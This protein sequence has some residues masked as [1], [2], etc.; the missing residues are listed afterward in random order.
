MKTTEA[1]SS[2]VSTIPS[3][4]QEL[5]DFV[6]QTEQR[7]QDIAVKLSA[8]RDQQRTQSFTEP[9][10]DQNPP[11]FID[12]LET[13]ETDVEV[14]VEIDAEA[15]FPTP[16]ENTVPDSQPGVLHPELDPADPLARLQAIKQRIAARIDQH[17][18][19]N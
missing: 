7:L 8:C 17:D 1:Q 4:Q 16:A 15:E 2:K 12:Q 10:C 13:P 5:T 6:M 3:L 18:A 11:T 14:D 19:S 9:T